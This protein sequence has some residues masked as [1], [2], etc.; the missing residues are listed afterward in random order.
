MIIPTVATN[1]AIQTLIEIVSFKNKKPNN[2]VIKG[3]AA[4][5]SKVIAALV[6]VIDQINEI[7]AIPR[8]APPINPDNPIY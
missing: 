5:H 3:I 8:P 4:R 2:A 7:M 6:C 1:I